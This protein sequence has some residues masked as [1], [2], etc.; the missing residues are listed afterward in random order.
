MAQNVRDD[1]TPIRPLIPEADRNDASRVFLEH[2]DRLMANQFTDYQ[3]LA[4][5][6]E[7]RRAGMYMYCDSAHFYDQTGSF[8]AFGNVRMEQ[9]DTLFVYGDALSYDDAEQL[10]K[11]FV[12]TYT[13]PSAQARLINR[14]VTLT[15]DT[16]SYDLANDLGYYNY[17]GR[18]V[19]DRNVLTSV[20]GEYSPQSKEATFY[21]YVVLTSIS[22]T[23]T[24]EIRTD[25][26][27]YNTLT[28][29]AI[30]T[31]FSKITN[32]D[33][34]IFTTDGRYNTETTFTE[35]F[36]RSTLVSR[37]GN[38]LT[39]DT[40]FFN[41]NLGRGEAF[42]N[43]EICDTT[44]KIIMMG[45]YGFYNELTDSAFVTGHAKAIEYSQGDSLHLH[46]DTIRTFRVITIP[47][48]PSPLPSTIQVPELEQSDTEQAEA[49]LEEAEAELN[50]AAELNE[51][52]KAEELAGVDVDEAEFNEDEAETEEAEAEIETDEALTEEEET[53]TDETKLI[54]ESAQIAMLPDTVR[55]LVA[56]P[57]VK[58][59]RSDIQ[60]V[61]D[62]MTFVS[63]DTMLWMNYAP[64][65]W[66]DNRQ[67]T[68]DVV[69]IH[70][71]DS[72]VDYSRIA[73]NAF[74]AEMIEEGYFNQLSGKE[75]I[76]NFV[77]GK[78]KHLDVNG[79]VLAINFPE[80]NDST[81]NKVTNIESSFLAADFN[82]NNI[83][84][85]KL[86]SETNATVTPLYL[87]RRSLFFLPDFKW[88]GD[89]IRP[90]GP[91][92]IFN[93][94]DELLQQFAAARQ[95]RPSTSTDY[96]TDD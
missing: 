96:D 29:Q 57:H 18:L 83:E 42:G 15:S 74:M 26:L 8:E 32:S 27:Y 16:L 46:G 30:L 3:I 87:A 90:S 50:E 36:D 12:D 64:V 71:N 28:H 43:I 40:L 73:P 66:S 94:T 56:A 13:N 47:T 45:D 2:A 5:N 24:L 33:G 48:P 34:T 86:W 17:G 35:L 21:T 79:N 93:F 89:A 65:L 81:F 41:R 7:F 52:D 78:L 1:N 70:L 62:S 51:I 72:T 92:D 11:V 55:Y 85:M 37:N 49:V 9:G 80:E 58:F 61:C 63:K 4:G 59:Y 20:S 91:D 10:C 75:M 25:N 14:N 77:D 69:Q 54:P 38:T 88:W 82:N 22:P 53:D 60:G 68:G 76:A 6:V 84:K 95:K 19:D 31:D 67:I 44:N 39:G 23:D